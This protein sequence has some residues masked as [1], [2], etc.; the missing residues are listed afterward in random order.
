MTKTIPTDK[1]D[2]LLNDLPE[3]L[4]NLKPETTGN[5]GLMT[6][7]HMVEHLIWSIKSSAK[8]HEGNRETPPN[9]RQLGFQKFIQN[10]AVLQHRP[11]DKT[12]ADLPPLKYGSL[13]EAISH[14]PEATQRF[15]TFWDT[16]QTY[17][18]YS[19]FMG[20]MSFEH[21]ELFHYMH[22]RYHL[23]QFGLI[24]QYPG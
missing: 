16:N 20:E 8:Q 22:V 13:E 2:F 15:Y 18:P 11:S 12:K 23:W 24:E 3:I 17:T 10:G 1:R 21:L 19:S 4:E 9:K 6:P 14:I 7:Q 5:F